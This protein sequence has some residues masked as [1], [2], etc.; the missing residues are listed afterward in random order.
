MQARTRAANAGEKSFKYTTKDGETRKYE[1]VE[2]RKGAMIYKCVENCAEK[3]KRSPRRKKSSKKGN[4]KKP[5]KDGKRRV[6]GGRCEPGPKTPCKKPMHVRQLVSKGKRKGK[7]SCVRKGGMWKGLKPFA[8]GRN[9]SDDADFGGG[10]SEWQKKLKEAHAEKKPS[11]RYRGRLYKRQ[12]SGM[13]KCDDSEFN[14][15]GIGRKCDVRKRSAKKK[16]KKK[17]STKKKST[18]K[19]STKKKSTKKKLSCNDV[20]KLYRDYFKYI[21]DPIDKKLQKLREEMGMINLNMDGELRDME[22]KKAEKLY[23]QWS[24]LRDDTEDKNVIKL[25]KQLKQSSYDLSELYKNYQK[26]I[27]DPL[28]K[29]ISELA[30]LIYEI[31]REYLQEHNEYPPD[32]YKID[33]EDFGLLNGKKNYNY[34]NVIDMSHDFKSLRYGTSDKAILKLL[35]QL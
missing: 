7:Y 17:K 18:K 22:F 21:V 9:C 1:L 35:K 29:K 26:C 23:N 25:L 19:K 32:D 8:G 12:K 15:S 5:C 3:K 11:F 10:A 4:A 20:S 33:S 14:E 34:R 27:Q 24:T 28:K 30:N 31:D 13:Y 16:S 6:N 2:G